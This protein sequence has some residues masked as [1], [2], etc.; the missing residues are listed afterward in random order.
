MYVGSKLFGIPLIILEVEGSKDTWGRMEQQAKAMHE[1]T[2]SLAVILE[3][4][5]V[6][7]FEAHIELWQT[8]RNPGKSAVEIL[9][10]KIHLNGVQRS[11][12][13]SL[14]YFLDR[15][16]EMLVKQMARSTVIADAVIPFLHV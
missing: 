14:D 16:I 2:S 1:V 5:L 3:C 11:L 8:K 4:F 15:L 9:C 10:E 12:S 7:V 13:D 6:F